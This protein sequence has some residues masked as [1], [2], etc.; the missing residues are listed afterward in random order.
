MKVKKQDLLIDLVNSLTVN[1]KRYF[2]LSSFSEGKNYQKIFDLIESKKVSSSKELKAALNHTGM[3]ISYEKK[4]LQ[5]L[6]LRALRNFHEDERAIQSVLQATI[7]LEIL[8]NK[9][10]YDLC[11]EIIEDN[12]AICRQQELHLQEIYLLKWKRRLYTRRGY[13]NEIATL[14]NQWLEEENQCIEQV[15]NLNVYKDI[16]AKMLMKIAKKAIARETEDIAYFDNVIN[17]P[18]LENENMAKSYMAK[19]LYYEAWVWY[20]SNTLKVNNAYIIGKKLLAL[21]ESHPN[22]IIDNPQHYIAALASFA[23]RCSVLNYFDEALLTIDKLDRLNDQK[24][25]KL[26]KSLHTETLSFV[27]EKR[28]MCYTFSRNFEAG[29]RYYEKI[30][31]TITKNKDFLRETFFSM[32]HLLVAICYFYTNNYNKALEYIRLNLD[33]TEDNQRHD[34]FLYTHMLHIMLHFELNNVELIPYLCK[35]LQRFAK[36]KNFKQASIQLFVK[37]FLE[38]TKANS[39]HQIAKVTKKYI[40]KFIDLNDTNAESVLIGTL[41]LNYWLEMKTNTIK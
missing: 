14:S 7:D 10:Q 37:M 24:G 4:Y 33:E 30:E 19:I 12:L 5:K 20:Y 34:N 13:Y 21:I 27:I 3:N 41:E 40:P 22:K 6:I 9:Q 17:N 35:Q 18:Y 31:D 11:L 38:L 8:F 15:K 36:S 39:N 16:Q 26:S 2:K 23:N 25:L 29:V 32:N 1:E 28:M